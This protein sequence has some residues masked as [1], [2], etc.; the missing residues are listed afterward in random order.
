MDPRI[1]DGDYGLIHHVNMGPSGPS[2]KTDT[3]KEF[4]GQLTKDLMK[5]VYQRY[6]PDYL[7]YGYQAD[8]FFKYAKDAETWKSLF[9]ENVHS[10]IAFDPKR[11]YLGA[12]R[13]W[14]V[15]NS[16]EI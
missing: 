11:Y 10:W 1:E 14:H 16:K 12:I 5:K 2:S 7:L 13:S 15:L 3:Q 9:H 6:K 4:F 8:T